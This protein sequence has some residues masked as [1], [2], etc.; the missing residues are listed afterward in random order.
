LEEDITKIA[1][2][3]IGQTAVLATILDGKVVYHDSSLRW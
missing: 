1:P 3:R 2:S